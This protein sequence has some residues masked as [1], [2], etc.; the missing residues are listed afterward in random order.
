MLFLLVRA[1]GRDGTM[2][3]RWRVDNGTVA[4]GF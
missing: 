3:R 1:E 2:G 4:G